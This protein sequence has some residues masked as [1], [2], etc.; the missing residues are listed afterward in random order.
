MTDHD[1]SL[2]DVIEEAKNELRNLFVKSKKLIKKVGDAF[3]RSGFKEESICELIK[4]ALKEEITEGLISS[5]TIELHCP[6]EW[7][8]KT[9]P[10][11][12]KPSFSSSSEKIP[13]A[14]LAATS[15]GT[16]VIINEPTNDEDTDTG[17]PDRSIDHSQTPLSEER[18]QGHDQDEHDIDGVLQGTQ[19][20]THRTENL[21]S[22]VQHESGYQQIIEFDFSMS[23]EDV[24]SA[25]EKLYRTTKG[26]GKMT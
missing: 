14:Q 6:P 5:R 18:T 24:R 26:L 2:D 10:K 22:Q 8:H 12:E 9:K 4:N 20:T 19:H 1:T 7:K 3:K 17:E 13:Q 16:S 11:N 15:E 21:S 25:I 23:F